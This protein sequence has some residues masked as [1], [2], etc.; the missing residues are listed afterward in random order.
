MIIAAV[1]HHNGVYRSMIHFIKKIKRKMR[2]SI[3]TYVPISVKILCV[4]KQD[5]FL[6]KM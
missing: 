1:R 3:K 2:G 6:K 4:S 5:S